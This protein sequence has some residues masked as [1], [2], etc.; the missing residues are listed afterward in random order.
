MVFKIARSAWVLAAIGILVVTLAGFDGRPTS[1]IGQFLAWTMLSMGFP[2]SL[3]YPAVFVG[4]EELRALL[5]LA[6]MMDSYLS[7]SIDW[8]VLSA[9]GYAQWFVLIPRIVKRF[10]SWRNRGRQ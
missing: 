9:L 8:L 1:D 5:G 7:L 4:L 10:R 3:V 2:L 6:P